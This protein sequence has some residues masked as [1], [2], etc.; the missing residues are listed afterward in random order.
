MVVRLAKRYLHA[1]YLWGGRSPFGIDCS[2]LTQ[3]VF[4][5][6]GINLPRDAWQQ[7]EIGQQI[8]IKQAKKGDLAFFTNDKGRVIHVGIMIAKHKI[9]HASGGV[10]IDMLDEKGIFN[11]DRKE[12]SHRFSHIVRATL[13]VAPKVIA[14]K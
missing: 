8:D 5:I 1:P 10:R 11:M 14:Q 2:G 13:V 7:A 12:Y 6:L 4:K 9:I 3:V